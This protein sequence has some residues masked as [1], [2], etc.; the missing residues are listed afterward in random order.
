MPLELRVLHDDAGL[1]LVLLLNRHLRRSVEL[2]FDDDAN[3]S[4]TACLPPQQSTLS[5]SPRPALPERW[6]RVP[7]RLYLAGAAHSMALA[8][9]AQ[10]LL[11][12]LNWPCLVYGLASTPS[13]SNFRRKTVAFGHFRR[14]HARNRVV[15]ADDAEFL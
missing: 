14:Y 10:A 6:Q 5:V 12:H 4:G 1:V 7:A 13:S 9:A 15:K 8:L 3:L 11:Q 2:V